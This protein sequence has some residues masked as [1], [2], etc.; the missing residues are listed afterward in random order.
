MFET[1]RKL[2]GWAGQGSV[3][4]NEPSEVAGHPSMV[5]LVDS[6]EIEFGA[7]RRSCKGLEQRGDMSQCRD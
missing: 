5:D 6:A 3:V 1:I 4:R 2:G 7:D